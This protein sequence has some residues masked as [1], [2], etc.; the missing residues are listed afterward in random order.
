MGK[1]KNLYTVS[2]KLSS[3][4]HFLAHTPQQQEVHLVHDCLQTPKSHA[5]D[6]LV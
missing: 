6:P 2:V 5:T 3:L 4:F 1:K